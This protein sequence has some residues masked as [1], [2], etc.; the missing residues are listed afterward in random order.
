MIELQAAEAEDA[1]V[2]YPFILLYKLQEIEAT[3]LID[4]IHLCIH[5]SVLLL[6]RTIPCIDG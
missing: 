4:C 3:S 6:A 1:L 2:P 5:S